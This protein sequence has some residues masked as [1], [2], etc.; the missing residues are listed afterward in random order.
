MNE[1]FQ[2]L[3][4]LIDKIVINSIRILDNEV[5]YDRITCQTCKF[6]LYISALECVVCSK[7]YCLKHVDKCCGKG[8]VFITRNDDS[9]RKKCLELIE[10]S[11]KDI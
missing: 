2:A 10:G 7:R 11:L 1:E 8:F 3:K 6:Y 9:R 4:K 5:K